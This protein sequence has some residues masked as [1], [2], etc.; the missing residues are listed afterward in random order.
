M[1][2]LKAHQDSRHGDHAVL[3]V[4]SPTPQDRA[5]QIQM[6]QIS[7]R[8]NALLGHDVIVTEIFEDRQS[9]ENLPVEECETLRQHYHVVPGHFRVVLVGKDEHVK[10]MA[11]SCVSFEE[12]VMRV[13]NE[14]VLTTVSPM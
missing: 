9:R 13:E 12:V 10:M 2:N 8:R 7:P 4:F 1:N 14:P 6:E 5:F 3:I 11:D